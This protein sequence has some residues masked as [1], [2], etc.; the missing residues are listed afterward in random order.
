MIATIYDDYNGFLGA[1]GEPQH[2][3]SS[4]KGTVCDYT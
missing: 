3:E 2:T 4:F 1:C